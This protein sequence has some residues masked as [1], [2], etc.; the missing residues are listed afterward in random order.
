[1]KSAKVFG[2][3]WSLTNRKNIEPDTPLI[4]QVKWIIEN[5]I[6]NDND[7]IKLLDYIKILINESPQDSN[8][9]SYYEPLLLQK[10]SPRI[11]ATVIPLK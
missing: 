10:L 9:Y 4:R 1:M 2:K 3:T 6:T 5:I 8:L 7:R 11:P